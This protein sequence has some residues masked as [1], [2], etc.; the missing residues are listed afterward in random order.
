[1]FVTQWLLTVF[2][3]TFPFELVA[4]VWDSFLVEGWKVVYR[5]LLALLDHAAGDVLDLPF[6][7]IL[8]YFRHFPATVDGPTIMTGSLKIALK[9]KHIQKH[10][11]E[12]RRHAGSAGSAA[13]RAKRS[14]SRFLPRRGS[15]DGSSVSTG[16]GS[17]FGHDR[18]FPKI[19]T[20]TVSGSFLKKTPKEIVIEDLSEPL[21]PI[22]GA[23]RFAVLL[24][25]VLTPEEC[26][27]LIDRAEE[28]GLEDASIYDTSTNRAH[29]NCERYVTDDADLAESWYERVVG[30]LAD[31]PVLAHKL[32]SAPWIHGDSV[33]AGPRRGAK[34]LNERLR[35]LRYKQGQ[36]FHAHNDAAFVR[37]PGDG[38]R[39]G[40]T[41]H[42]TVL[43]YLNQ[44]FK[45]GQTT[46]RGRGRYYDVR[47]RT[48]SVLLFEHGILHEGKK[49]TQGKKYVVRTDLMYAATDDGH[50]P[51]TSGTTLT[52][53]L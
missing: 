30:A 32:R 40:E 16:T 27:E 39:A 6:E 2:T 46:F 47:P 7:G 43:V 21:L 35:L 5:V 25:H 45:G 33:G 41:S 26:A 24:H 9:R 52:Q 31:N 23:K 14:A 51:P 42:V 20:S 44:K 53:Q 36:F 4:R 13:V 49:V 11:N 3:S 19:G 8:Q 37:G 29:R 18:S 50:A 34:G 38:E 48:G 22:V 15:E 28:H 12:W 1:M 17:S 10:V